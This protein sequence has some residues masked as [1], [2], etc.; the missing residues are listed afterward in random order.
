MENSPP[1]TRHGSAEL[2]SLTFLLSLHWHLTPE[3]DRRVGGDTAID[4]IEFNCY[5]ILRAIKRK[6]ETNGTNDMG[7]AVCRVP[8]MNKLHSAECIAEPLA[9]ILL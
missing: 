9:V 5:L 1:T 8:L 4:S 7:P 6:L 2:Y 3:F